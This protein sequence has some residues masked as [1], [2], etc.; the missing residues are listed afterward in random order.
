MNDRYMKD[1]IRENVMYG[2]YGRMILER[3]SDSYDCLEKMEG[4]DK[5]TSSYDEFS[6]PRKRI[7]DNYIEIVIFSLM[8]VE[9]FLNDY[10][11]SHIGDEKFFKN[12]DMLSVL[13]KLQ[14]IIQFIFEDDSD[15]S[16]N[17]ISKLR[18]LNK[19]RNEL[20][21][22]KSKSGQYRGY[23][24]LEA[25]IEAIEETAE[26]DRDNGYNELVKDEIRC[27]RE[28]FNDSK[29]AILTVFEMAKYFDHQDTEAYAVSCIFNFSKNNF[30]N[31]LQ[32]SEAEIQAFK[33]LNFR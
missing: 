21:H 23:E 9:A 13:S 1:P 20:V 22:S 12:F 30:F 3:L 7:T 2:V 32:C 4:L 11:A 24:S 14:L 19:R 6:N 27:C 17:L 18:G 29:Q 10:I 31:Q 15:E 5:E 28:A 33:I 16:E 25:A 26:M 8:C